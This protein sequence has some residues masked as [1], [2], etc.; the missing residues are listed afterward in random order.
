MFEWRNSMWFDPCW[1]WDVET[2]ELKLDRERID[3][4][5]RKNQEWNAWKSSSNWKPQRI[6]RYDQVSRVWA[7]SKE[8][9]HQR[10][11]VESSYDS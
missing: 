10:N 4:R 9:D 3:L 5:E 2:I 8:G 6:Q 1:S 7:N 11:V